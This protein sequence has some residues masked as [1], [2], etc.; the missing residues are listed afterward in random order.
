MF[1]DRESNQKKRQK[2]V[3]IYII[4]QYLKTT[5]KNL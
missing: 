1:V 4:S 3:S 2:N 5:S